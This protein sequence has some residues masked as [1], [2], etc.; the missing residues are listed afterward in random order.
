[1]TIG[2][3]RLSKLRHEY[4][5]QYKS[6]VVEEMMWADSRTEEIFLPYFRGDN[7]Y[8]WQYRDGNYDVNY[9]LT[10]YYVRA[11]DHLGILQRTK[12]DGLFGAYIYD[13]NNEI[14]VSRDLIDS[15]VEMYFLERHLGISELGG[16][17]VLDIGAGYGRLAHRMIDALPGIGNVYCTDF[18]PES[19]FISEYYLRFRNVDHKAIVVPF[20]RHRRCSVSQR[21]SC[22]HKHSLSI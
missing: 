20:F 2:N 3:P 9:F 15:V 11:M 22:C 17:N 6:A 19:T 14:L 5:R 10:M 4:E 13:F 16:V 18:I 21:S 1:M 7:C 12:E 8:V